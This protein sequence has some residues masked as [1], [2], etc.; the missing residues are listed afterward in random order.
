MASYDNINIFEEDSG[1]SDMIRA[2]GSI[3][4]AQ[5]YLGPIQNTI[6]QTMT[7]FSTDMEV[8]GQNIQIPTMVPTQRP[9]AIEYM[10]NMQGGQGFDL[11]NPMEREIIDVARKHA[12]QRMRSNKNP[13]YQDNEDVNIFAGGLADRSTSLMSGQP[14]SPEAQAEA[15][16]NQ[17]DILTRLA[18]NV[19]GFLSGSDIFNMAR[20]VGAGTR[21]MLPED[22]PSFIG[23]AYQV[24]PP[25]E[26]TEPPLPP[27]E[28]RLGTS[29]YF[30]KKL[31]GDPQNP[32]SMMGDVLS[33]VTQP[34]VFAFKALKAI[35]FLLATATTAQKTARSQQLQYTLDGILGQLREP[36]LAPRTYNRLTKQRD[37][38]IN[39]Q[40]EI[41][42]S[43]AV[44]ETFDLTTATKAEKQAKIKELSQKKN[45]VTDPNEQQV[46]TDQIRDIGQSLNVRQ[47]PTQEQIDQGVASLEVGRE[48]EKGRVGQINTLARNENL[49]SPSIASMIRGPKNLKGNAILEWTRKNTKPQELEYLGLDDFIKNNPDATMDEAIQHASSNQVRINKDY[50]FADAERPSMEFTSEVSDADPLDGS[51]PWQYRTDD[52]INDI[53]GGDT[54]YR[55]DIIALVKTRNS[56]NESDAIKLQAVKNE[57]PEIFMKIAQEYNGGRPLDDFVEEIAR[58]EYYQNPYEMIT[59]NVGGDDLGDLT[60]AYGNNETGYSIFVD[61]NRIY[62]SSGDGMQVPY[63]KTEAEIQ[64]RDAIVETQGTDPYRLAGEV[65]DFGDDTYKQFIDANLPG[66]SEYREVSIN[67]DNADVTHDLVHSGLNNDGQNILHALVRNRKLEDGTGTLH[68]DEL[69]SDL[70]QKGSKFGYAP[71]QA[72]I[73]KAEDTVNKMLSNVSSDNFKYREGYNPIAER[74]PNTVRYQLGGLTGANRTDVTVYG[75][76]A[77][78][79]SYTNS[80]TENDIRMISR[81]I[82]DIKNTIINIP[83]SSRKKFGDMA[84]DPE[85]IIR[86][87]DEAYGTSASVYGSK[88]ADMLVEAL[89]ED[90]HKLNDLME[91]LRAN[92]SAVPNYPYKDDWHKLGLK[93]MLLEA[94][95]KGDDAISTSPAKVFSDRY[96]DGYEKFYT[97]LYD[98]KIPAEMKRLA[99][100]YGGKFEKGSL[101]L[102]DT[103]Y[104]SRASVLRKTEHGKEMLERVKANIL[105]ITPS[106]S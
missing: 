84:Y 29:E 76:D 96:S 79:A 102:N 90:F 72:E 26:N 73:Q 6:G 41:K 83:N 32:M 60:F 74:E 88:E 82:K 24:G 94:I 43:L 39:Q 66:G 47:A 28:D 62:P 71:P 33:M 51:S 7:E 89:G 45:T 104:E 70:H 14:L 98:E 85:S 21:E 18:G 1:R 92:S 22:A 106:R 95:E 35:P 2:D 105:R 23:G 80:F 49:I 55:Q 103:Y 13:F 53:E 36:N 3:K 65:D 68:I 61:G 81:M 57:D 19:G 40:N 17:Y 100:N 63:S 15:E 56:L 69:Q 46:I 97:Q 16:K 91:P 27:L 54:Y 64:L 50:R 11:N 77:E 93:Q 99:D 52:I 25:I 87:N 10:R 30:Q 67:W 42:Q 75:I 8:D 44:E 5:G 86:L 48:L 59:P 78:N 12:M 9:E 101:D 4:S 20:D 31:G 38:I 34:E 58:N 37:D